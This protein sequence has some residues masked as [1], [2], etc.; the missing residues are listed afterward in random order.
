M[1]F[2][3]LSPIQSSLV[4][5]VD[6]NLSLFSLRWGDSR[7]D[8][9]PS[10]LQWGDSRPRADCLPSTEQAGGQGE[11]KSSVSFFILILVTLCFSE[12][13]VCVSIVSC[14]HWSGLSIITSKFC[15]CWII[16]L[17]FSLR[18][19]TKSQRVLYKGF[20]KILYLLPCFVFLS[21]FTLPSFS[22][23]GQPVSCSWPRGLLHFSMTNNSILHFSMTNN[24]VIQLCYTLLLQTTQG[25]GHTFSFVKQVPRQIIALYFASLRNTFQNSTTTTSSCQIV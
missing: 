24:R 18:L 9:L 23:T 21:V 3:K 17:L 12:H 8:C 6:V 4:L 11:G 2:D 7:T 16:F 13:F 5:T 25:N 19:F 15:L 14:Y 22:Q 10:S 20:Y 1:V